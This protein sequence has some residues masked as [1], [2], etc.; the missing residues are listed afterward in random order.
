MSLIIDSVEQII[1]AVN[2]RNNICVVQIAAAVHTRRA[3]MLLA[4]VSP[5][6]PTANNVLRDRFVREIDLPGPSERAG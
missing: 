3:A 1:Y 5:V 4:P 6:M 2:G